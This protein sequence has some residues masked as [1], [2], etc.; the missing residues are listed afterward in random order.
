LSP[1]YD[2]RYFVRRS[3]C[4]VCTGGRVT[5]LYRRSMAESPIRDFIER[6][7][8][9]QGVVDWSYLASTDYVLCD[10][11]ECGLIYQKHV[12]RPELLC[13]I[14]NVMI[15]PLVLD[16][17]EAARLTIDNFEQIS[18]EIIYLFRNLNKHPTKI[19]FLD[20]GFGHGR[21]ARVARA[22]GAKVFGT[23]LSP[24]K[25]TL[26]QTLGIEVVADEALCGMQFDLI[27][28]EQVFEHLVEPAREFQKLGRLLAP[29]GVMKIAVP[30]QGG[31]RR[32]LQKHGIR[33][34]D[35]M[36]ILSVGALEHL[37]A[38]SPRSMQVLARSSDLQ[39][40]SHVRRQTV[41][42]DPWNGIR[43]ARSLAHVSRV[44]LRLLRR[45]SGYYLFGR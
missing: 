7:Y 35:Y 13:H 4:P 8:G 41:A 23:E 15:S 43:V 40:I 28:T 36:T 42:F 18:G 5:T 37:N 34:Q 20:Y 27:H 14:Y 44:M 22:M 6:H 21:W 30:P 17:L 1:T 19:R 10:C 45:D 26:A 33:E 16:E 25:I 2:D 32:H 29:G 3:S 9:T 11:A 24:E 38:F 31:I 12:P 39:L